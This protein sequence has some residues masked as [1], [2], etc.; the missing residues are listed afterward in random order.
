MINE[1]PPPKKGQKSKYGFEKLKSYGDCIFVPQPDAE[2]AKIA[3][4]K[5]GKYNNFIVSVRTVDGGIN[6][7]HAGG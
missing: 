1:I 4:Y 3:A 7:Y 2:K 6:V 5:Y